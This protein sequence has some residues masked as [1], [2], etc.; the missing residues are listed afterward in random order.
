MGKP[1]GSAER[2]VEQRWAELMA[3]TAGAAEL[4]P[5][6]SRTVAADAELADLPQS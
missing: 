4:M 5:D 3:R 2:S 6:L 1:T